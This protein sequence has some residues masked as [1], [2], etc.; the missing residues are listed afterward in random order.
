MV[1]RGERGDMSDFGG[2]KASTVLRALKDG[3]AARWALPDG[4][5]YVFTKARQIRRPGSDRRANTARHFVSR[6]Y[7]LKTKL[8]RIRLG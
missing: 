8:K 2:E 1:R 7:V 3:N 6:R 4:R 5:A